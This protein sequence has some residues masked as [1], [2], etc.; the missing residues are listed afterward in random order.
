MRQGHMGQGFSAFPSCV[1]F[2]S[3]NNV[4][5]ILA[6]PFTSFIFFTGIAVIQLIN[7]HIIFVVI[8]PVSNL[9]FFESETRV[10]TRHVLHDLHLTI[11]ANFE[12]GSSLVEL[13]S[14]MQPL[15]VNTPLFYSCFSLLLIWSVLVLCH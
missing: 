13:I 7:E 6:P 4:E 12:G 15:V 3:I 5:N 2:S 8:A 9:E 10:S 11:I 14:Y 1:I